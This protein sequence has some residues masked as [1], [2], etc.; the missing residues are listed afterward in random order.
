MPPQYWNDKTFNE[1][2]KSLGQVGKI[3]EKEAK[4]QV[5][6]DVTKPLH[7]LKKAQRP[8]GNDVIVELIYENLMR[9]CKN[10]FR[11]SHEDENCSDLSEE[12]RAQK[13]LK[14]AEIA[15]KIKKI[16]TEI[17]LI[18][19]FLKL[20]QLGWQLI[21]FVEKTH[22]LRKGKAMNQHRIATVFINN[23]TLQSPRT[24]IVNRFGTGLR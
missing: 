2:G 13:R 20:T 11:I 23:A 3:L 5:T 19:Q 18:D 16:Q 17:F 6:I 7:F 8:D 21:L 1:I 24:E 4:F 22:T 12:E 14:K 10:C 15:R 9:H